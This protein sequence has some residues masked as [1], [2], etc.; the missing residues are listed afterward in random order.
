MNKMT[1]LKLKLSSF[2]KNKNSSKHLKENYQ[3]WIK[4]SL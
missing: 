4:Y 2:C 1:H 3:I